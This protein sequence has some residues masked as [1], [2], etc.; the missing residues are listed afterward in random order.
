MKNLK[1]AG[2]TLGAKILLAS[3]CAAMLAAPAVAATSYLFKV[4]LPK[5]GVSSGGSTNPGGGN[6]GGG[7]EGGGTTPDPDPVAKVS[8][9]KSTITFG[10]S[11]NNFERLDSLM[12]TNDGDGPL[13]WPADPV[14]V[15]GDYFYYVSPTC[16]NPLP[17]GSSC[18][19]AVGFRTSAIGD[20]TGNMRVDA[21][22]A[23]VHNVP[24]NGKAVG[25]VSEFAETTMDFGTLEEG[26]PVQK[27]VVLYNKGNM[28]TDMSLTLPSGLADSGHCVYVEA[29]GSCTMRITYTPVAGVSINTGPLTP[30]RATVNNN[31]LTI[32]G[33]GIAKAPAP[34]K[35]TLNK[36]SI[37]FGNSGNNY[38][39]TAS[40][41]VTND[42][43]EPL[44]WPANKVTVTGDYFYYKSENC[45]NPLPVGQSCDFA[46]GFRTSDIGDFT[47]NMQIDAGAAGIHNVPLSGKAVGIVS[48]FAETTMDF[49][50]G[51]EGYP[52]EKTVVLY[53]KGNVAADLSLT[54]PAGLKD[55]GHCVYV[56]GGSSCTMRITYTPVA[57]V[58]IDTG[59]LQPV[60]ATKVNNTLTITGKGV[61]AK[62]TSSVR[63][64]WH[65]GALRT[66]D[67]ATPKVVPVTNTGNVPLT[68]PTPV[69]TSDHP[70]FTVT[71]DCG[72]T[73]APGAL[74]NLTLNYNV[75]GETSDIDRGTITVDTGAA[76]IKTISV[77]ASVW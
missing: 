2:S 20:F 72:T 11:G 5:T 59:P 50:T 51:V 48:E 47:G 64:G 61:A 60:K 38:E 18:T 8:L 70:L 68:L 6:P 27:T 10:N 41:Y 29:G 19:F 43:T 34:G 28:A 62:A 52:V 77:T 54:L 23:G 42:G 4:P 17:Q 21:G 58:T 45:V 63:V 25:V 67:T 39:T 53:N 7:D 73:L 22:K 69:A 12:V 30:S 55:S 33:N 24:L 40:L 46:L 76:G 35:V 32:T 74:C 37:K 13:T 56:E 15:T 57:G 26:T 14:T 66:W 16:V 75:S 3:V 31:S 71:S 36:A 49:G 9:N 44:T 65:F 1:T